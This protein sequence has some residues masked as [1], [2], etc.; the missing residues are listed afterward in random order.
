MAVGEATTG[1][2]AVADAA[3]LRPRE[4]FWR[5]LRRDRGA[6]AGA[7]IIGLIILSALFAGVVANDVLHH[8]VNQVFGG[9][10]LNG[11]GLPDGPSA[12][13]PFGADLEGRDLLVR[14]LY[15]A[16]TALLIGGL[17][18]ALA[19][20]IGVSLGLLGGYFGGVIDTILARLTDIVLALPLLLIAI[21]LDAACGSTANGCLGGALK[22]GTTLVIFVVTMFSWPY[23]A[24][25]VRGN[26]LSLREE[27]FVEAAR[28]AG[29]GHLR[30]IISE[31]LPNLAGPII[32]LATIQIPN[33]ILFEAVLS[34]LGVG[35]PDTVPSWGAMLRDASG[36]FTVAWWLMV[37]PG[38]A[39]A[40]TTSGFYLLGDGL[41]DALDA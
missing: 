33:N 24:R 8:G 18:T 35:V 6:M 10:T 28:A 19:I 16:R 32:V 22:P 40:V 26:V 7:T 11:Y 30:I 25:V 21:G 38:L 20:V 5:R 29:A 41:R 14:V 17:G 31:I 34:F 4:G 9:R 37:F 3:P 2:G 1:P 12:A 15:G 36:V 23:I 39:L 13:F 27:E